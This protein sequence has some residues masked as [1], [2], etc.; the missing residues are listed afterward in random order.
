[1]WPIPAI[2]DTDALSPF[3]S[4]VSITSSVPLITIISAVR[5]RPMLYSLIKRV[6]VFSFSRFNLSDK[7]ATI[8]N[9]IVPNINRWGCAFDSAV[10]PENPMIIV[11]SL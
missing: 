10:I 2:P 9:T 8:K 7:R 11:N 6:N 5:G 4:G 3:D 1:M